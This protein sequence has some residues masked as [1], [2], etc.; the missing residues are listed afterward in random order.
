MKKQIISIFICVVLVLS[1]FSGCNNSLFAGSNEKPTSHLAIALNPILLFDETDTVIA[2]NDIKD[3][4]VKDMS[5]STITTLSNDTN[6]TWAYQNDDGW[7][8]RNVYD[9]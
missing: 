4:I 6:W 8:K 5:D 1:T 3:S 7:K 2:F 9:L